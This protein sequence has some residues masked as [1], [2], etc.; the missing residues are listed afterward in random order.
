MLE[1][2]IVAV[3]SPL[4]SKINIGD[5]LQQSIIGLLCTCMHIDC[6]II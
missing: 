1:V 6:K 3:F 4:L 5:L 2:F